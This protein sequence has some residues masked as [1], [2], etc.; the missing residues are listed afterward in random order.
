M[1][2]GGAG[3]ARVQKRTRKIGRKKVVSMNAV[4]KARALNP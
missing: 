1:N 3:E 4:S 2:M